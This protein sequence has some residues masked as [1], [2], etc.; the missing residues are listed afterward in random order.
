MYTTIMSGNDNDN[1]SGDDD[2]RGRGRGKV[3]KPTDETYKGFQ[4]AY[5]VLNRELFGRRLPPCMITLRT[6]GKARGYFSPDR[7]VHLERVTTTHE[8]ALDPRQFM[9]RT[10]LQVLSTLAHEMC[11]VEQRERGTPSRSGYHNRQ[12]VAMM[13]II[14]LVPSNTGEPGGKQTGQNMTHYIEPGGRFEK[15]ATKLI[16]SGRFTLGWADIEGFIT[17]NPT[18]SAKPAG[19]V[20]PVPAKKRSGVRA[21]YVC[22]TCQ[23][24]VWGKAGLTIGCLGPGDDTHDPAVMTTS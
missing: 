17:T 7:F 8:I 11:H 19:V 24:A 22:P 12:W 2:K 15:T 3:V 21:K 18:T 13:E 6:F 10:S 14:G 9:D 1:N 4:A 5:D 20:R 16:N 23:A